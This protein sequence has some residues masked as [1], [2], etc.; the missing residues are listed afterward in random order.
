MND[1]DSLEEAVVLSP[2]PRK[3]GRTI[4]YHAEENT[5]FW[6]RTDASYLMSPHCQEK[7]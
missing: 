4:E 5:S 1:F 7:W 2:I 3:H 6:W